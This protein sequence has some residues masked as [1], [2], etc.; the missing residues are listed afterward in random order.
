MADWH[1]VG[2]S[3]ALP[4][5]DIL[6]G[7]PVRD[8]VLHGLLMVL[9]LWLYQGI[10]SAVMA[11]TRFFR[12]GYASGVA[13]FAAEER[14]NLTKGHLFGGE[15]RGQGIIRLVMFAGWPLLTSISILQYVQQRDRLWLAV[16]VLLLL[17]ALV[18]IGGDGTRGPFLWAMVS[19]AVSVSL[20]AHIRVR[21]CLWLA[22]SLL[23]MLVV[24][25]LAYKL[26]GAFT[27]GDAAQQLAHRIFIGNG[28][29]SIH[30]IE[31]VRSGQLPLRLGDI[32]RVDILNA[33]PGGQA[34]MAFSH[35]LFLI[36]CQEAER[37]RTTFSSMTYIGKLYGDFGWLGCVA[38]YLLMGAAT[39]LASRRLF[40]GPKTPLHTATVGGICL[41]L[42]HLNFKGPV[43]LVVGLFVLLALSQ[44]YNLFYAMAIVQ[45]TPALLRG[46]RWPAGARGTW[47][48]RH[49]ADIAPAATE[50]AG[51]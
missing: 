51:P 26:A 7:A 49:P 47:A 37:T 46:A 2:V 10:P 24:L 11:T 40:Q 34:E 32:H 25:S 15:Y 21:T 30:V 3:A 17:G 22:A 39:A 27:V 19:I 28:I 31:L 14:M 18:Y 8:R 50:P 23:G 5:A 12:E 44:L 1:A 48:S 41:Q 6:A 4:A 16:S 45:R 36:L 9:G 42:G 43:S 29:N 13:E 33:L 38:G 20:A 35:E